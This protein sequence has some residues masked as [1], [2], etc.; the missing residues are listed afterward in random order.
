MMHSRVFATSLTILAAI[1]PAL[2]AQPEFLE[3]DHPVLDSMEEAVRLQLFEARASV[4]RLQAAGTDPDALGQAFR[5]L[6]SLY[7][8]YDLGDA[9]AASLENASRLLPQDADL[10]YL[11]GTLYESDRDLEG[12]RREFQRAR[13]LD[14]HYLPTLIRLAGV[15]R[16]LDSLQEA[17]EVLDQARRLEPGSAIVLSALGRLAAAGQR[18]E[19]A[20][21]FFEKALDAQPS[22]TSIHYPLSRAYQELGDSEQ[23]QFHLEHRGEVR[24]VYSDPVAEQVRSGATGVAVE[25]ILAN[26]ALRSGSVEAAESRLRRAVEL[27][28]DSAA[29][30]FALGVVLERQERSEEALEELILAVDLDPDSLRRR[31][32]LALH[33]LQMERDDEAIVVL[34]ELLD[35]APEYVKPREDLATALTRV[36]DLAAAAD[37]FKRVLELDPERNYS[38]WKRALVLERSG[39][40]EESIA[41]V[42]EVLERTPNFPEAHFKLANYAAAS[43][44]VEE[45]L[46]GY[47]KAV[48]FNPDLQEAH[49]NLAILLGRE[50][51]F[52]ESAEHWARVAEIAP[53]NPQ[54]HLALAT[55]R[56]LGGAWSSAREGLEEAADLHSSD[57]GVGEMLARLLAT[58]PDPSVRNGPFAVGIARKLFDAL[59]GLSTAETLA[60]AHAEVGNFEAAVALQTRALAE[61]ETTEDPQAIGTARRRLALYQAGKPVRDVWAPP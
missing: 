58:A 14:S 55:A 20:V 43:G 57:P 39:R 35:R 60:M 45:A 48:T 5:E 25:L 51:R 42:R 9:A 31:Q 17:G 29:A 15:H 28:P 7:L 46:A 56:I 61:A 12:A 23:A 2:H 52:L 38:R 37:E 10:H 34:R 22:A 19:D 50:E 54:T 13:E 32:A 47:A 36:G 8:V 24:V 3:I 40:M 33:L 16:L 59:P 49:L 11:L 1:A 27:D 4:E 41:E 26:M 44:D 53:D 6:G 21:D 18:Y 30:H